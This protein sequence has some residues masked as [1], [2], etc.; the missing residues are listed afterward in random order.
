MF[1]RLLAFIRFYLAARVVYDL[2]S[3]TAYRFAAGVLEDRRQYYCFEEIEHL[4]KTLV[5]S[6]EQLP[7]PNPGAG[8]SKPQRHIGHIARYSACSPQFGKILFKTALL[9]HP[10]TIIELGTSLGISAL[11]LTGGAAHARFIGIEG[12]PALCQKAQEHFRQ[13]KRRHASVYCGAF[14]QILPRALSELHQTDLAFFDGDHRYEAT[15]D[16]FKIVLPYASENAVFIFDDI[17]WSKGMKQAW[18]EIRQHPEVKLSIATWRAGFLFF[19]NH[20]KVKQHFNLVPRWWKPW[21]LG[22]FG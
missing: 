20:I 14:R 19:G 15:L 10:Q 11:Y 21:R 7:A 16:L 12:N 2:H 22:F 4:R 3:P 17:H 13:F 1:F 6:K 8:S 5:K 9:Y 18:E